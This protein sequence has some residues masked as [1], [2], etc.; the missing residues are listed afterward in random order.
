MAHGSSVVYCQTELSYEALKSQQKG[1]EDLHIYITGK[2]DTMLMLPKTMN[3]QTKD[4]EERRMIQ[5]K[6]MC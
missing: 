6:S 4:L 1:T 3:Q 5:M 2:K